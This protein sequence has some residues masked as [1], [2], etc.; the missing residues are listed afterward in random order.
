MHCVVTA[1][2]TYES[3]DG[4]R[5]LTNQSTG[6]LGCELA[7][8]LTSKAHEVTLLLGEQATYTGEHRAARTIRFTNTRDLADQL[9]RIAGPDVDAVFHA[10]AVSDFQFGRV[11]SRDEHG[12][13][14]EI[15]SGKFETRSGTLLAELTPTPKL[16]GRLRT[17]FPKALLAGWKYE[18]DGDRDTVLT[19]AREQIERNATDGCVVNGPAWGD[20]FGLVDA[21]GGLTEIADRAELYERLAR[22]PRT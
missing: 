16:I 18:V 4:V 17:W 8:F 12:V 10:A 11:Y 3:L 21:R 5:R 20:G 6:R 19:K 2:P 13:L 14:H 15:R 22:L 7:T 9:A 1:G